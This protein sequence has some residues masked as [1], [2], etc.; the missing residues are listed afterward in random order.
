MF[1]QEHMTFFANS[2][3]GSLTLTSAGSPSNN[4]ET[5]LKFLSIKLYRVFPPNPATPSKKAA[6]NRFIPFIIYD[7]R[8]NCK[9]PFA[10]IKTEI[11]LFLNFLFIFDLSQSRG[12]ISAVYFS[13][14]NSERIPMG[15][16]RKEESIMSERQV[17]KIV[18][19]DEEKCTGCGLCVP[20]CAEGAIRVIDGKARLVSEIYCDGLGACLGECPEGAITIEE[21]LSNVYDEKATEEHLKKIGGDPSAAHR[22]TSPPPQPRPHFS[23]CPGSQARVIE[24]AAG[25]AKDEGGRVASRLRQWPIQLHLVPPF[26]PFLQGADLLVAAD[27]SAFAYAEFH[28]DLLEGKQIVIGCPKLDDIDYYRDKLTEMFK[29]NDLKSVTVIHMEVPCCF[30]LVHVTRTALEASGKNIPFNDITISVGGE[31]STG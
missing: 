8:F 27:C 14:I 30:G 10:R 28:R 19:I 18:K 17:R 2:V 7:Y 29:Q 22:S 24:P 11:S 1:R 9:N 26:A 5:V 6:G 25:P 4:D 20:A 23:G 12:R 3:A 13:Q 16:C 21:R 31:I 15:Y